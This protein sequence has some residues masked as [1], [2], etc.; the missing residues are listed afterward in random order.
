MPESTSPDTPTFFANLATVQV[1]TDE[2]N[3]EFRRFMRTHEEFHRLTEGGKQPLPPVSDE[4]VYRV[5]PVARVVLT[6]T[7]ARL[8]RDN[9]NGLLS[10]FEET[11]KPGG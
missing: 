8:L 3:I 1:A 5:P 9:L 10:Q 2:V 4:E 7:S 6:F 11:R